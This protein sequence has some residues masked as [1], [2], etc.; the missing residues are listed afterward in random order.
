MEGAQTVHTLQRKKARL[1]Y[2]PQ[3]LCE[4]DGWGAYRL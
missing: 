4:A 2:S 3:I 1:C